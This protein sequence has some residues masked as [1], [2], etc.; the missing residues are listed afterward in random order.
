M[1]L[2]CIECT[3]YYLKN[4]DLSYRLLK[5]LKIL[6]KFLKQ[7]IIVGFHTSGLIRIV[8]VIDLIWILLHHFDF[9]GYVVLGFIFRVLSMRMLIYWYIPLLVLE[10]LCNEID[11]KEGD[12]PKRNWFSQIKTKLRM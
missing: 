5:A 2:D 1:N 11:A 6:Y 4:N 3:C 10:L 9:T 7:N 8:N 12:S